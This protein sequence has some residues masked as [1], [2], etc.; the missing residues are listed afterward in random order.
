M[1]FDLTTA[2][3]RADI[4]I[5]SEMAPVFRVELIAPDGTTLTPGAG[6][7]EVTAPGYRDLRVTPTA[8]LPSGGGVGTWRAVLSIDDADLKRWI[9]D[10]R[11]RLGQIDKKNAAKLLEKTLTGIKTHGAPYSLTVQAHSA[12]HLD[13]TLTQTSRLPGTPGR[14]T[15]TLTDSGIPLASAAVTA[16]VTAPSGVI[17]TLF[18]APAEPGEFTGEIPTGVS[19]VYQVRVRAQGADLHGTRF[20]R[21]EL[22][23]LAV[24]ARGDDS[25]PQVIDPAPTT[26]GLDTCQLLL[27]ILQIDA[28]RQLLEKNNI[29]PDQVA[30][31]VKRACG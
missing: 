5:L 21:E 8:A 6:A 4:I 1:P 29:D 31:C 12:L 10:L 17:S 26:S 14:L 13:V 18:L 30:R 3:I 25:P 23:T 9:S 11:K 27:C 16:L 19:G 7:D 28:V 20:T 2:D 22:R 24:W 15:A